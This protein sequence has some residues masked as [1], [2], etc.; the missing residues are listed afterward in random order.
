MPLFLCA[1]PFWCSALNTHKLSNSFAVVTELFRLLYHARICCMWFI[2]RCSTSCLDEVEIKCPASGTLGYIRQQRK[3]CQTLY[4]VEDVSET[5]LLQILGPALCCNVSFMGT[6]L[7]YKE[8]GFLAMFS[9]YSGHSSYALQILTA[10]G[11][12][13]IG[14]VS[15]QWTGFL[16]EY[17]TDA[18]TYAVTFPMDL[19]VN[20]K[21]LLMAATFLIVC[22]LKYP[23]CNSLFASSSFIIRNLYCNFAHPMEVDFAGSVSFSMLSDRIGCPH[24]IPD[25][26]KQRYP[27]C[28]TVCFCCG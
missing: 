11:N 24:S 13:K 19:Q 20:A 5:T 8:G 28:L 26:G 6:N 21:A 12:H 3:G 10:D 25:C 4:L 14:Q 18:D 27:L 2:Y 15:K 17:L 9:G 1:R 7:S 22:C 16:Q 23:L